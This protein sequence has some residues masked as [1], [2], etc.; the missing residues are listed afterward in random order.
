MSFS[1]GVL[2]VAGLALAGSLVPAQASP[3][4]KNHALVSQCRSVMAGA[5]PART[6]YLQVELFKYEMAFSSPA[7]A[8]ER[9][10]LEENLLETCQVVARNTGQGSVRVSLLPVPSQAPPPPRRSVPVASVPAILKAPPSAAAAVNPRPVDATPAP[11]ASGWGLYD[12]RPPS[13]SLRSHG[14]DPDQLR[15]LL[16]LQ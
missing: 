6:R 9:S 12:F 5:P 11:Q 14:I 3:G 15:T 4:G 8:G 1:R 13:M 2:L 7:S 16:H 10:R